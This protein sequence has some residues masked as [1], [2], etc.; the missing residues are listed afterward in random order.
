MS[1]KH[2]SETILEIDTNMTVQEEKI[3]YL[4]SK[5]IENEHPFVV[6]ENGQLCITISE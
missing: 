5:T 3:S 4:E 2:W 6:D 1:E